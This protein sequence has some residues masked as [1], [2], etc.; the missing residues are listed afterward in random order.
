ME[1]DEIVISQKLARVN[2]AYEFEDSTLIDGY[3]TVSLEILD[4][5]LPYLIQ[6]QGKRRKIRL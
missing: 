3:S 6:V 5:E 2:F 4:V 1:F